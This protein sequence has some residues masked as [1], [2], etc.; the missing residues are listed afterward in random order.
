VR[1]LDA[2]TAMTHLVQFDC[3][4]PTLTHGN[5]LCCYKAI[6]DTASRCNGCLT[7]R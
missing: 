4:S 6:T 7:A 5:Y 3:T 2:D 1:H